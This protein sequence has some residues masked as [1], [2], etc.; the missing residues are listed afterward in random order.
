MSIRTIL[1]G[2]IC[3]TVAGAA[4][5]RRI[6][7][8]SYQR[9]LETSDVVVIVTLEKVKA[10]DKPLPLPLFADV[11]EAKCTTFK[12]EGILKRKLSSDDLEL[13]HCH[14]SFI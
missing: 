10:W 3:L 9:L 14:W 11:L 13:V 1:T 8:W 2:I 4:H 5:A 6:E 12:V 7:D